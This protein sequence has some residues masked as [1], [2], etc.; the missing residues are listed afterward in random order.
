M[1][2]LVLTVCVLIC[3]LLYMLVH[4][5][6]TNLKK[7]LDDAVRGKPVVIERGG[8]EFIIT[9]HP[10][11]TSIAIGEL[12]EEL[13][14][15]FKYGDGSGKP[16]KTTKISETVIRTP[17]Q[18]AEAVKPAGMR[19]CKEGHPMPEGRSKCLGKGCKYA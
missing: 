2:K 19:F 9:A 5:F 1:Y 4:E 6:R 17:Q 8:M 3:T 18:A 11:G 16:V 10:K 13:E 7:H 15:E 14:D 12:K